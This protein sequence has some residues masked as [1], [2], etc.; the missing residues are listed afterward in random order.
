M[1]LVFPFTDLKLLL[2]VGS[3]SSFL[4]MIVFSFWIQL[5]KMALDTGLDFGD[6]ILLLENK[7][8]RVC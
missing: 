8:Q 1:M 6:Q 7:Y 3:L 5:R 2:L 4:T